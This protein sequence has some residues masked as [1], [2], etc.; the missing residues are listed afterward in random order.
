M[1]LRGPVSTLLLSVRVLS[2]AL[3]ILVLSNS[4]A[5]TTAEEFAPSQKNGPL[6][7][8]AIVAISLSTLV[9]AAILA[10]LSLRCVGRSWRDNRRRRLLLEDRKMITN[11]MSR[12]GP[13][14]EMK[15]TGDVRVLEDSKVHAAD[16][17]QGI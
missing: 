8:G 4:P 2:E 16:F 9:T 13:V 5:Q 11:E 12:N 1:H 6:S 15:Q 14:R 3:G 17:V 7:G 10:A